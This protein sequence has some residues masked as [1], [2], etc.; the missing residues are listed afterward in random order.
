MFKCQLILGVREKAQAQ[1][2]TN[3]LLEEYISIH[4]FIQ[5]PNQACL[6]TFAINGIYGQRKGEGL[7]AWDAKATKLFSSFP[8]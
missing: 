8:V 2:V 4:K 1:K 5:G 3:Y 6:A 7:T